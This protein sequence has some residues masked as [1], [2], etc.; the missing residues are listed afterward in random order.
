MS[1]T[2]PKGEAIGSDELVSFTDQA[3]AKISAAMTKEGR[4]GTYLRLAVNKGGCSGYEYSVKFV[5]NGEPDDLVYCVGD[6]RVL[7]AADSLAQLKG[8]VL[9][10]SD[11]LYGAGLKFVNPNATHSCGCGA[12]FTTS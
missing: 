7:V 3:R 1:E 9:D 8:T 2:I 5:D 6:I 10:Y 11:G 12:S 4:Q